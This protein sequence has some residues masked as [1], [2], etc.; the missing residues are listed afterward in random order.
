MPRPVRSSLWLLL[1]A[2]ILSQSPVGADEP[3]VPPPSVEVCYSISS[4]GV[5]CTGDS[6]SPTVRVAFELEWDWS[7][8]STVTSLSVWAAATGWLSVGEN[9]RI[10]PMSTCPDWG[11]C[12]PYPCGFGTLVV[13]V[14]GPSLETDTTGPIGHERTGLRIGRAKIVSSLDGTSCAAQTTS[15]VGTWYITNGICIDEGEYW[16]NGESQRLPPILIGKDNSGETF[17]FSLSPDSAD[18]DEDGDRFEMLET[19]IRFRSDGNELSPQ[20]LELW[21]SG[22]N[23]VCISLTPAYQP[24]CDHPG[25][26]W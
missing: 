3:D 1:A 7:M 13:C 9:L 12:A 5:D 2:V 8:A 4:V 23:C 20:A 16:V 24:R 11:E 22:D 17:V 18:L 14:N 6:D 25:K 15:G 26:I 10:G 19:G 21:M